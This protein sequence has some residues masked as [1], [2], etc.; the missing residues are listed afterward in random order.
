MALEQA[1]T[2]ITGGPGTGKTTTVVKILAL[3]QAFCPPFTHCP[4]G[5]HWQSGH[6]LTK[7]QSVST[8]RISPCADLIMSTTIPHQVTTLHRLLGAKANSPYFH[9]HADRPLAH[10]LVVVDEASMID[11]ALMSKLVDP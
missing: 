8:L 1:F 6:A 5:T 7:N 9:H 3:M 11:L 4:G 10:D 2:L